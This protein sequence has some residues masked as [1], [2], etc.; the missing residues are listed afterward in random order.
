MKLFIVGKPRKPK[1]KCGCEYKELP[2]GIHY[3]S[4][5]WMLMYDFK[6][7]KKHGG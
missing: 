4:N 7:C 3:G 6:P 1:Y 2:K 5:V